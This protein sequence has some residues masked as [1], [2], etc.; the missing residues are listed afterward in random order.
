MLQEIVSN[1][2]SYRQPSLI[3]VWHKIKQIDA[4]GEEEG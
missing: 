4:N 1:S 2:W 3:S